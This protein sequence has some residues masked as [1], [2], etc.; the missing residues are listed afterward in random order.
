MQRMDVIN[1][2]YG[3]SIE[4]LELL[5]KTYRSFMAVCE[6]YNLTYFAAGGT[7]IGAIRHKGLIPWDDDIDVIMPRE[8]YNKFLSLKDELAGGDYFILDWK[9]KGYG[10]PFAKYC[11]GNSTLLPSEYSSIAYG[12]FIDVFPL[13]YIS[14]D[15]STILKKCKKYRVLLH[16]YM[17]ANNYVP[18]IIL[19]KLFKEGKFTVSI[20]HLVGQTILRPF[21]PLLRKMISLYEKRHFVGDKIV[22]TF[23]VYKEREIYDKNM[24]QDKKSVQFEDTF[25][26]VP[27]RYDDYLKQMYKNYMQWPPEKDRVSNHDLYYQNLK[28]RVTVPEIIKGAHDGT[29]IGRKLQEN[30]YEK[31]KN[32]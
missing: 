7:M 16:A 24:F 14:G 22:S 17:S 8:D 26:Y 28:R 15:N 9:D 23:G 12:V 13:D 18:Y 5:L 1:N 2:E 30:P 19:F 29:Y 6:K 11:D 27:L 10:Q 31:I 21:R 25:I 32:Y 4:Y 20:G 3:I